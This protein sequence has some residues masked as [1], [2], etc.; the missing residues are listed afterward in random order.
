MKNNLIALATSLSF[1]LVLISCKK[2]PRTPIPPAELNFDMELL[3]QDSTYKRQHSVITFEDYPDFYLSI[4][5]SEVSKRRLVDNEVIWRLSFDKDL[6][7][8]FHLSN[9]ILYLFTYMEGFYKIDWETGIQLENV[10]LFSHHE[11]PE[12]FQ[13]KIYNDTVYEINRGDKT[14]NNRNLIIRY[15]LASTTAIDTV[16]HFRDRVEDNGNYFIRGL[17]KH[18]NELLFVLSR[19]SLA[20]KWQSLRK[21]NTSTQKLT[22]IEEKES[23]QDAWI[24]DKDGHVLY[25]TEYFI[26][27]YYSTT[28]KQTLWKIT[29]GSYFSYE[30]KFYKN[31]VIYED[32][33]SKSLKIIDLQTG[34]LKSKI[35]SND[36]LLGY[37]FWQNGI[38]FTTLTPRDNT[39]IPIYKTY[40]QQHL[41]HGNSIN[42]FK[43][44]KGNPSLNKIVNNTMLISKQE[45]LEAYQLVEK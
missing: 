17:A 42:I 18:E 44:D 24:I 36:P 23:Y 13:L 2:E 27:G 12:G 11:R 25:S 4:S 14:M 19:D 30:Y 33:T 15:P 38:F 1:L 32:S 41:D 28:Q 5:S 26:I 29:D 8:P 21:L 22:V 10:R 43:H 3:W 34:A 31:N 35:E 40:Y 6:K 20:T 16:L 7:P 9:G 39:I 45:A 37:E